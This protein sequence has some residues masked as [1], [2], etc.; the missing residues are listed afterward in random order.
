MN[1]GHLTW[2]PGHSVLDLVRDMQRHLQW[3]VEQKPIVFNQVG[4]SVVCVRVQVCM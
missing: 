3:D 1:P 4:A 2:A